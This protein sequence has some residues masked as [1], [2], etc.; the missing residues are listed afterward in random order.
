MTLDVCL[1]AAMED[2]LLP[3]GTNGT[4]SMAGAV[5]ELV[6]E[7]TVSWLLTMFAIYVGTLALGTVILSCGPQACQAVRRKWNKQEKA[8]LMGTNIPA[9]LHGLPQDAPDGIGTD[10]IDTKVSPTTDT[11]EE[12]AK[13]HGN[14]LNQ[15]RAVQAA[16]LATCA[17]CMA[18]TALSMAYG[19]LSKETGLS[20]EGYAALCGLAC[21]WQL[22]QAC[23]AAWQLHAGRQFGMTAFAE[24]TVTGMLPF[25]SDTFDTLKDSLFGGLCLQSQQGLTQALGVLSWLYLL[26][27][28]LVLL[29]RARFLAEL[30]KNYLAIFL[31]PTQAEKGDSGASTRTEMTQEAQQR[32]STCTACLQKLK[33]KLLPMAY[34][35]V[36]PTKRSLLV[37]ENAPQA[38]MAIA[39]L[40]LEGGS[41]LV[42]VL[43]L[44]IPLVQIL[45]SFLLCPI[46]RPLVAPWYAAQLDAAAAD[47][48]LLLMRRLLLEAGRC[49]DICS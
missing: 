27:F 4:D 23:V 19:H 40:A 15:K 21:T 25:M 36:T 33:N 12:S 5:L 24:G 30:G 10:G 20:W 16:F 31:A 1:V 35:Q 9:T 42:A 43:N 41:L 6:D 8:P 3:N 39:Y 11:A 46:L 14:K 32:S 18:A 7:R 47:S 29:R 37:I 44:A 22:A 2:A 34:A 26:G 17:V 28:H 49:S 48:N 13:A 38:L 45:G